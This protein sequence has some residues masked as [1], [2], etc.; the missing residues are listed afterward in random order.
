MGEIIGATII[1]LLLSLLLRKLLLKMT[2]LSR[3]AAT[4]VAAIGAGLFCTF[5]ALPQFGHVALL[6]YPGAAVAVWVWL[7]FD[8]PIY[9]KAGS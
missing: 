9:K 8:L 1:V 2:K 7:F 6:L 3:R 5:A 4:C